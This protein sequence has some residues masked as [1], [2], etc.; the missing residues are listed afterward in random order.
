VGGV[1]QSRETCV[2]K[3]DC[4]ESSGEAQ[5][6]DERGG[7]EANIGGNQEAVGSLPGEEGGAEGEESDVG[8]KKGTKSPCWP[9]NLHS[10]FATDPTGK[11]ILCAGIGYQRCVSLGR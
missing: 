9:T 8:E 7:A 11:P 10:S 2:G 1:P 3:E 6:D 4:P 5:A